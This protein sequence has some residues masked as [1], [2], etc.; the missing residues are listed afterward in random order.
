VGL[1]KN[2]LLY[3]GFVDDD[4]EEEFSVDE[5][6]P[7]P[8]LFQ[9]QALN[10]EP[11]AQQQLASVH[12]FPVRQTPPQKE[13]PVIWPRSYGDVQRIGDSLRASHPVIVNLEATDGDFSKRVIAFACGLVYGLDGSLKKLGRGVY[14]LNPTSVDASSPRRHLGR[15]GLGF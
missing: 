10:Y 11:R 13:V 3:L 8:A 14:L 1:W 7:L 4:P 15:E 9:P 2:A 6:P 5:S 12:Q